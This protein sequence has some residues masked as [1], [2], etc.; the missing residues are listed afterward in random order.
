V[1]DP[2]KEKKRKEEKEVERN[3]E[4]KETKE[5]KIN[6]SGERNASLLRLLLL[7]FF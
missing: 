2:L 5:D 3:V 7:S 4:E 1:L 6:Q